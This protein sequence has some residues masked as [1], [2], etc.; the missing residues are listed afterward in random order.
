MPT[1]SSQSSWSDVPIPVAVSGN[2]EQVSD[3]QM[4]AYAELIYKRTGIHVSPQ[5][6]TLL[7]NRLRRRLRN[8]GISSFEEYFKHL[9]KL[10]PKD[11]EWDAFLQEITTHET[12]LFR[13]EAQWEWFRKS[14]LPDFASKVRA[15]NLP[16]RLRVWSA[17]CSTGDEAMTVATCVASAIPNVSTWTIEIVGTDIGVGAV[18]QARSGVFGERAMRLVPKQLKDRYFQ[19]ARDA[20]I[21][22]AKPAIASMT[23]FRQHNLMDPLRER[24]FDITFLK[25]VLIYFD[26]TSK[27]KVLENVKAVVAPGGLLVAGAAEGVSDLLKD[28]V[29]IQPWLYQR[30]E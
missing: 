26:T 9:K 27:V 7:S 20:K 3:A 19:M 25:N 1:T 6:K 28:F 12:Y 15:R 24:P 16:K 10:Q 14:F 22:Q 29:R 21:W 11:P 13:D 17:A 4:K 2:L 18:E 5:K 23:K 8:T 30:P